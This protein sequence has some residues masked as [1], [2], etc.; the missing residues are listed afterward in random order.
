MNLK[1]LL[2]SGIFREQEAVTRI[3]AETSEGSLGLLPHRLDCAAVLVP[4]I[5]TYEADAKLTY[6]ALDAGVL[7]KA[8]ADVLIAVRRALGGASLADLQV[9]VRRAFVKIDER[10]RQ[11]RAAVAKMEAGL[12]GRLARLQREQ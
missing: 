1:I 12:M 10:E 4:G 3:V 11:V 9:A 6:L 2:P 5:L 8:G 7:V